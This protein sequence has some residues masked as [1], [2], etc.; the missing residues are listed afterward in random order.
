M[1]VFSH[2]TYGLGH[3]RR[4]VLIAGRLAPTSCVGSVLI[5]T[6]SPRAQ[7]FRL[8]QGCDTVK[9]PSVTKTTAGR[10][11][12]RAVSLPTEA[13]VEIR[14]ALAK[15]AFEAFRPD[16]VLVDHAPVGMMGELRPLLEAAARRR[17]RTTVVLGLRDIIDAAASVKEEWSRLDAWPLLE[18]VYDRIL[19]YGDPTVKTTA[20]ELGLPDRLPSKVRHMGYLGRPIR[21]NQDET[22]MILVTAGG[23]GDGHDLLR[24]YAAYLESLSGQPPFRS[25]V[26]GGPLMSRRRRRELAARLGNLPHHVEFLSFTDRID[27][28]F[29]T[30]SGVVSMAGYNT[31]AEVLSV[32]VP[33]LLVP[34][35]RPRL[36]QRIRAERIAA[37]V[38]SVEWCRASET[39]PQ[40]IARFV[41]RAIAHRRNGMRFV[42]MNG[43]DA[44]AAELVDLL[45]GTHRSAA[46]TRRVPVPA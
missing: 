1:L 34:R 46:H 42:D 30:A 13:L 5:V 9:L 39:T 15:S 25:V 45:D 44:V 17:R 29:A 12:A 10:Y 21:I 19:V 35:E 43:V 40:R 3:L 41:D 20:Q 37:R 31:V 2:D 16:L 36:E 24:A 11:Q 7:A 22:P 27:E 14:S 4:S 26:I 18:S 8:P 32:G 38:P 33:A 28:L 6:G 23:G